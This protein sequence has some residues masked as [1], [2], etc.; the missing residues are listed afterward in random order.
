MEQEC[1]GAVL[2]FSWKLNTI[3]AEGKAV[4]K[5]FPFQHEDIFRAGLA[6]KHGHPS[7]QHFLY[8]VCTNVQKLAIGVINVGYHISYNEIDSLTASGNRHFMVDEG[9]DK[10]VHRFV[11]QLEILRLPCW[12]TFFVE[13]SEEGTPYEHAIQDTLLPTQMLSTLQNSLFTDVSFCVGTRQFSAHRALLSARSSVFENMFMEDE[14]S[15]QSTLNPIVIDDMDP[16]N[17][18]HLL[19]FLYTGFLPVSANNAQ[20]KTA[21]EKYKLVTLKNLCAEA[22]TPMDEE[23]VTSTLLKYWVQTA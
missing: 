17:F 13:V 19:Q 9:D 4:S 1:S 16:T 6:R 20:L 14:D 7:T 5:F 11:A 3:G 21:A 22:D 18:E 2:V 10:V 15:Q 23:E 8:F 12:I